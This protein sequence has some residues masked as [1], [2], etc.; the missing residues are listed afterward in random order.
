M[1]PILEA[2]GGL[3]PEPPERPWAG[4][5]A[6]K[7]PTARAEKRRARRCGT[8]SPGHHGRLHE[9]SAT[10]AHLDAHLR[11][12]IATRA[13]VFLAGRTALAGSPAAA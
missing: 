3:A 2:L 5:A 8:R 12:R 13:A 6:R 11:A 9:L 10:A 7:E 4:T 1:V